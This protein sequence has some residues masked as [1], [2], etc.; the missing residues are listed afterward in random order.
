MT[1][2]MFL[3]LQMKLSFVMGNKARLSLV[4]I[5]FVELSIWNCIPLWVFGFSAW[6]WLLPAGWGSKDFSFLFADIRS[7]A[8]GANAKV[9]EWVFL[10]KQFK[11]RWWW[12][13]P[14]RC[15]TAY[16]TEDLPV[17]LHQRYSCLVCQEDWAV[18]VIVVSLD[19]I[20]EMSFSHS[21]LWH[22]G[23]GCYSSSF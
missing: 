22:C 6:C 2:L 18:W 3:P 8:S 7:K 4:L 23:L 20:S 15:W 16:E 21:F 1:R 14:R 19:H 9:E 10:D 12:C 17:T 13:F 11:A 5:L